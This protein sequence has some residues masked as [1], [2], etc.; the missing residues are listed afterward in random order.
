MANKSAIFTNA[1][2]INGDKNVP[3]IENGFIEVDG[4][5]IIKATGKMADLP[6]TNAEKFDLNGAYIMPGLINAHCHFFTNGKKRKTMT[7]NTMKF[8][9]K[10]MH[11]RL[12]KMI[13]KKGYKQELNVA[14]NAGITTVRDV[15]S[16][17]DFD[18]YYRD[19]FNSEKEIGPRVLASGGL[20]CPTGGHGCTFPGT[21]IC[22]GTV[23]GVKAVRAHHHLQV[24]WIKICNTGGV[25]DAKFVG[26]A[27]MPHMS[28][29]EISAI[30]EEAH[31]RGLMVAS[32]CESTQGM[33][34][35]L[36][37]GVDTIEHG[38]VIED[39]MIALFKNNPKTLRGYTSV[40]P[41]IMAG[42]SV[43][44]NDFTDTKENRIIMENGKIVADGCKDAL[45]KAVANGIPVGVGDDASVPGVTHYNLYKE[46]VQFEKVG[47]L[48][49]LE[50][51]E[52]A[53]KETAQII[54]IYSETGSLDVGKSADFIV[55]DKNPLDDLNNI[56]KPKHVVARGNRIMQPQFKI[57]E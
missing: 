51:I 35:A 48:T 6:S 23:E 26:E 4:E 54:N 13:L 40:I 33:R 52:K 49:K 43:L 20:I 57:V 1:Y 17:Y 10:L 39:D 38:G 2:I 27:G 28:V 16:M 41:T 55:L 18:L 46:L 56:Y 36:A 42:L 30:C 47:G 5:G 25:S 14:L 34:D 3:V 44:S 45:K 37:G 32:H 53:T 8:L 21:Y 9:V 12:G 24:D 29:E 22:D 7:G 50:V 15:G 11:S 31:K 19:I